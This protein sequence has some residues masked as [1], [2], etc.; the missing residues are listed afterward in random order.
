[1]KRHEK[2]SQKGFQ[3]QYDLFTFDTNSYFHLTLSLTLLIIT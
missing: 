1:M 3:S 2:K